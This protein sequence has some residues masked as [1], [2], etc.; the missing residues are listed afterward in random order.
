MFSG[1]TSARPMVPAILDTMLERLDPFI[2]IAGCAY[3]TKTLP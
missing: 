3:I 2:L 1:V